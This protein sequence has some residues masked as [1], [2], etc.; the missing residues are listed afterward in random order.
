MAGMA[1]TT[2]AEPTAA[3]AFV[4]AVRQALPPAGFWTMPVLAAVSGGGDSVALL[5]ALCRLVPA[6]A[7]RRLIV[8]HA[9]HDLRTEAGDDRVFVERLAARF[10]LAFVSRRLPVRPAGG[11]GIEAAAR[12]LRYEFLI[13]TASATGGRHVVV[14]HTAD[15]QAETILHRLLRGT[16]VA[17]LAGMSLARELAPGVSLVRPLLGVR[18]AEARGFLAATGEPWREDA[19]NADM[20]FARNFVRHRIIADCE[21]GPYPAATSALVRLGRQAAAV[22]GAIR[23]AAERLLEL[24]SCRHADG[25]VLVRTGGLTGLDRQLVAEIFVAL[26]RCEG[27]PR[28]DMTAAHYEALAALADGDPAV[29]DAFHAPG[30]IAV[31]RLHDGTLSVSP[32]G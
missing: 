21:A 4:T 31:R 24:N 10:G 17:G 23:S 6:D 2:D 20:R 1:I 11:E 3:A 5:L 12:R 19:T 14:A 22:A 27:W 28:R 25:T 16:G 15:D 32:G 13:E 29:P 26:W 7:V 9:E 8:V 18:R 30:G